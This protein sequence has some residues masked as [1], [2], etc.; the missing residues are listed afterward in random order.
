MVFWDLDYTKGAVGTPLKKSYSDNYDFMQSQGPTKQIIRCYFHHGILNQKC[1]LFHWIDGDVILVRISPISWDKNPVPPRPPTSPWPF[2][3]PKLASIRP[4]GCGLVGLWRL[5][6]EKHHLT[7]YPRFL[8]NN[9][10]RFW[11]LFYSKKLRRNLNNELKEKR[12][13]EQSERPAAAKWGK[14]KKIR[15]GRRPKNKRNQPAQP[16]HFDRSWPEEKSS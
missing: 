16:N 6:A 9:I 12:R 1:D 13:R 2:S 14:A 5:S 3:T 7:G 11:Q 15:K 4:G 8:G 10:I